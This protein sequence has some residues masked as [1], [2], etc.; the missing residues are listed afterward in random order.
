MFC[1]LKKLKTRFKNGRS[2]TEWFINFR[3][4]NNLYIKTLSCLECLNKANQ[5]ICNTLDCK[6]NQTL[7]FLEKF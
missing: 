3:K 2:D 6:I 7:C 1:F 5:S 4:R